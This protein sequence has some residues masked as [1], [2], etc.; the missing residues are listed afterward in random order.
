MWV[1]GC[2]VTDL[3]FWCAF[4]FPRAGGI[5]RGDCFKFGRSPA[6]PTLC[7]KDGCCKRTYHP[8]TKRDVQALGR[9]IVKEISS[10]A[11]A[12]RPICFHLAAREM[13]SLDRSF[14]LSYPDKFLRTT[15]R[16][17]QI[18]YSRSYPTLPT[19]GRSDAGQRSPFVFT[20]M[21]RKTSRRPGS[22]SMNPRRSRSTVGCCTRGHDRPR[23]VR[24]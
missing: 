19:L 23:A 21:L 11:H 10:L 12:S 13:R 2:T 24:V 8:G 3:C 6:W 14:A 16:L 20:F 22:R 1:C 9:R 7:T 17:R 5:K 15:Q 4:N 18:C